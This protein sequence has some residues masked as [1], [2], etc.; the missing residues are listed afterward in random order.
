MKRLLGLTL[1]TVLLC[2][3]GVAGPLFT[4]Y[5]DP[6][7]SYLRADPTDG[8]GGVGEEYWPW[9]ITLS[10]PGGLG[11][12]PGQ[13]LVISAAGDLCY[14]AG[15]PSEANPELPAEYGLVFASSTAVASSSELN[16][17]VVADLGNVPSGAVGAVSPLTYPTGLETDIAEDF[18]L[19]AGE[20]V[21]L[22][23]PDRGTYHY[24]GLLDSYFN[25]NSDPTPNLAI[26]VGT[27]DA[28]PE[29]ATYL[30][31]F[32]GLAGLWTLRRRNA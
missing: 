11:L 2:S 18:K 24:I 12:L 9:F 29:P 19:V 3:I 31:A 32:A 4:L 13:E 10:G 25:D 21:T 5:V 17:L 27:P 1:L 8:P 23:I 16:R 30:M 15:C 14:F 22:I 7:A 28:V 6:F 26:T 20:S